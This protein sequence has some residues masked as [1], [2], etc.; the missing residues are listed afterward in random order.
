[1]E[2]SFKRDIKSLDGVFDFLDRCITLHHLSES[3]AFTIKF[4]TEEIF[5]NMA[6]Y[7]PQSPNDISIS[8][9]VGADHV[10][11]KFVD[12]EA[13]PFDPTRVKDVNLNLPINERKPGGLGIHLVKKMMDKVE[14]EYRDGRNHIR[15]TKRIA[16]PTP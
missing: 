6:K 4:A 3:L 1:M 11:V 7:N 12:F 13:V 2:N 9:N 10:V 8:L 14:Y 16:S 15:L 5:T